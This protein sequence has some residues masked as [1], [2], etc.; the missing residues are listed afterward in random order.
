[1]TPD[2]S[3]LTIL[4]AES[5]DGG[6]YTCTAVNTVGK[7]SWE[8]TV[9][10]KAKPAFTLPPGLKKPI[11]FQIDEMMSLKVPL[12]AVP[13]P[14]L[15]LEKLDPEKDNAVLNSFAQNDIENTEVKLSFRHNFAVI[16]MECA[17]KWHTGNSK[18]PV[19]P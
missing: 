6:T 9:D 14:T 19:H 10:L 7:C 13:E 16:K 5:D 8:T 11:A 3:Q 17:Q 1:M 12:I 15:L 18:I 4:N 2:G